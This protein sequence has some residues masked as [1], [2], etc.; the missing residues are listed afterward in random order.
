MDLFSSLVVVV[1]TCVIALAI[2]AAA[3]APHADLGGE[4]S[5]QA[6]TTLSGPGAATNRK[7]SA[8]H[9]P[10]PQPQLASKPLVNP[11]VI[12]PQLIVAAGLQ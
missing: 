1:F 2:A 7:S 5:S 8:L 12:A 10:S 11:N 4:N 6:I 9:T 3:S